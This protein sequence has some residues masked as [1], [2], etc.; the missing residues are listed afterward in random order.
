MS[1][2][3]PFLAS[4]LADGT[5]P[6]ELI[7]QLHALHSSSKAEAPSEGNR[8]WNPHLSPSSFFL[9]TTPH[10]LRSLQIPT[11]SVS[12][13]TLSCSQQAL[14]EAPPHH[15]P[16]NAFDVQS[17]PD[18]NLS[19]HLLVPVLRQR[20]HRLRLVRIGLDVSYRWE[21][22]SEGFLR[23]SAVPSTSCSCISPAH[24]TCL[25]PFHIPSSVD[26]LLAL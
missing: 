21:C 14:V 11:P 20:L 2:A 12:P 9:R 18:P 4:N 16:E 19:T 5:H 15:H 8:R 24:P 22:G 13:C 6:P 3:I 17:S 1:L 10:Q 23:V 7:H 26:Y 25:E